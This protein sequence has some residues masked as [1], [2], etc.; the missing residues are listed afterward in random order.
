MP[1]TDRE[2]YDR[3]TASRDGARLVD[4]LAWELRQGDTYSRKRAA[5]DLR[6]IAT[7]REIAALKRWIKR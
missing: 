4:S 6:N 3:I 7:L 5:W 2:V 1:E